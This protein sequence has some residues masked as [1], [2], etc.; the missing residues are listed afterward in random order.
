MPHRPWIVTLTLLLVTLAISTS[1]I[2]DPAD[3][4]ASSGSDS[5]TPKIRNVILMI[6][7]GM[8]P[9]QVGLLINYAKHAATSEVPGRSPAMEHMAQQSHLALVRTDPHGA[10]VTDSAAA[11]TQLATGQ[12]AGSEMIGL[13]YLGDRVPNV[14]EIAKQQGKS[15]GLVSDTRLT[16]ATPASFGAHQRHRTMENEI[17]VDLLENDIDVL[18]SGG[19]R[20]WLPQAVNDKD[21][22]AY[23]AALQMTGGQFEISS[24]REDNRNLLLEARQDRQLVFDHRALAKVEQGKLLGLF[25]DS[26]MLDALSE[27]QILDSP[28]RT[29]PTLVEMA[30]KA[31]EILDQNPNGFFLMVEGGQ[32]DWAGHNNDAGV[33]LHEL[34]QFDA[35]IRAV[36]QWAESR[37]DTLVLVTADHETGG[38]GFSYSGVSLP[39]P[40]A[41]SGSA[42]QGKDFLPN[43]NFARPEVLDRLYQQRKSFFQIF[44][45]FDALPAEQRTPETLMEIVNSAMPS[46]ITLDDAIAIL[47]RERNRMYV[48][49][50]AYLGK[51]T[52]PKIRDFNAYYLFGENGR[53]N[54]LGRALSEQ[55][56]TVWA[57]GAHTSTPVLLLTSGPDAVTR[58][59]GGLL[60]STDIGQQMI[61]VLR[62][63]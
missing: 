49:G 2:A 31:I 21:S 44:T 7:D 25:A 38:F 51:K 46:Q 11:A 29:Q 39:K 34:L 22:A 33:L 14:V 55:L 41:L 42:F 48:P 18:M 60:H 13:N 32:I 37:D 45:E 1:A 19:L 12:P 57:T 30:S 61:H 35:T 54:L 47:A 43:F 5:A 63:D 23:V 24:K 36:L 8:G 58:R 3:P 15:T 28:D 6:G 10:L 53:M 27:R 16:H 4:A 9:Q 62:G 20:H 26:E 59:F 50:H 40:H 52:A 56:N 17:A